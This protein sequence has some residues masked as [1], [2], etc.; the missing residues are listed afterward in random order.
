MVPLHMISHMARLSRD[1]LYISS[2]LGSKEDGG[3]HSLNFRARSHTPPPTSRNQ[4]PSGRMEIKFLSLLLLSLPPSLLSSFS[5]LRKGEVWAMK[6]LRASRCK[7]FH[8]MK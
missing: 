5:G 7:H 1:L 3:T 2:L 6:Q 8:A 4:S